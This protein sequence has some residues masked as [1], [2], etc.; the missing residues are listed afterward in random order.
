MINNNKCGWILIEKSKLHFEFQY[1]C[2]DWVIMFGKH[3]AVLTQNSI[4]A[5]NM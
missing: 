3:N 2:D 1:E 5:V 4:A